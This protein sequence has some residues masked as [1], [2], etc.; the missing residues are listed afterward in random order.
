MNTIQVRAQ[1]VS[2]E[3]ANANVAAVSVMGTGEVEPETAVTVASW[4][5]S[6][7]AIG[8][9]LA[10]FASGAAVDRTEL[11]DDISATVRSDLGGE[12]PLELEC[13]STFVIN[14]GRTD[15]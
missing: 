4:Y 6:P 14:Y 13:L 9:V 5:Q 12:W 7:G 15:R 8:H 1:H 11:L 10:S 2:S 3:Y